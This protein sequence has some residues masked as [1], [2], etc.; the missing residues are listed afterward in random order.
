MATRN[1]HL[2]AP[3]VVQP[4]DLSL[5]ND[6]LLLALREAEFLVEC[7]DGIDRDFHDIASLL[8][9][10]NPPSKRATGIVVKA[11]RRLSNRFWLKLDSTPNN[12]FVSIEGDEQTVVAL[13]ELV[14]DRLASMRPWY[15]PLARTDFV[16]YGLALMLMASFAILFVGSLGFFTGASTVSSQPSASA[17]S[18]GYLI[19]FSVAAGVM[20]LGS[21][22]NRLRS[23]LFPL[24]SF[25]IG[26]GAERHRRLEM[27]RQT[28]VIGSVVSLATGLVLSIVR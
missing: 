15:G 22:L 14:D 6:A 16:M 5:L 23:R 3:L 11:S 10:D 24:A 25:V 13:S 1:Q 4:H 27:W 21:V 19:V 18:A 26:H 12:V 9:Y 28:V 2:T 17:T 8:A 20:G 7:A